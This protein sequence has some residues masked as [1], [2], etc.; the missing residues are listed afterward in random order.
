MILTS[1]G[2]LGCMNIYGGLLFLLLSRFLFR[3]DL[4]LSSLHQNA[5]FLWLSSHGP[6]L[7]KWWAFRAR[8]I[9]LER[10]YQLST[11]SAFV[12][13]FVGVGG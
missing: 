11:L 7:E 10:M 9:P 4:R 8:Q 1:Y 2:G 6:F 12:S 13:G 5:S 3:S